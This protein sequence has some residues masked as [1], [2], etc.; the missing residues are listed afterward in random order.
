MATLT[1]YTSYQNNMSAADRTAAHS[2]CA[3][4]LARLQ[5]GAPITGATFTKLAGLY[6]SFVAHTHT[7]TDWYSL[8][9]YGN[10]PTAA[11]STNRVSSSVVSAAFLTTVT[12][13]TNLVGQT[14]T[15]DLINS[16]VNAVNGI[17]SHYH[18]FTDDY[19]P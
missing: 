12:G 19:Y 16:L 9:G 11:T 10:W 4:E 17:R 15:A 8:A 14:I 2:V 13:S 1:A 3:T 7:L 6:N 18:T 5:A